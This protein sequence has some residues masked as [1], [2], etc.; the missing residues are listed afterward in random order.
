VNTRLLVDSIVRQTTVLIA[1]LSTAAGIRAPL[2]HVADEV[3]LTLAQEIEA[4]GVGRK[5][6]ADMF[7]M[8]LRAY[9]KK[10]QRLSESSTHR[11]KTLWEA[12]FDFVTE[13]GGATRSEVVSRFRSDPER[14][15]IGVLT[16]LVSSGLVHAAGRGSASVYGVTTE[17]ER[18]VVF[19]ADDHESSIAIAWALL[20]EAS[21]ATTTELARLL[22]V[23]LG[24]AR[25]IVARLEADG[26]ITREAPG[27]DGG[28]SAAALV[29][30]VGAEHGWEAAVLDHYRAVAGAIVAKVRRGQR[31]S[32]AGDTVGGATLS[33]EISAEHP[34]RARV[35]ELL[36]RVRGE[37]NAVWNEVE[38]HN[39]EHAIAPDDV[40]RVWFYVGQYVEWDDHEDE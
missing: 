30:P 21:P 10:V 7:G 2:S 36:D 34:L 22:R 17:A 13:R 31:R 8:A 4:Q 24:V 9:Q 19:E 37:V 3:F 15:V 23:D 38:A 16:D 40:E 39:R 20:R 26:R 1:Q 32:Q 35:H 6:V 12:V 27:D 33:F 25:T 14:E 11:D 18:R 29:L 5:V 28:L